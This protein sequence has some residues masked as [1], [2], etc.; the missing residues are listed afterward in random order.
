MPAAH[1]VHPEFGLLC[2][3]PRLRRKL[4]VALAGLV[5]AMLGL[6][7][8]WAAHRGESSAVT[9]LRLDASGSAGASTGAV[10]AGTP[11]STAAVATPAENGACGQT[12]GPISTPRVCWAS[13]AS[14]GRCGRPTIARGS[15]QV[16]SAAAPW[17][18][19]RSNPLPPP[20]AWP[21]APRATDRR[22]SRSRRWP[23]PLPRQ[24]RSR[25]RVRLP[26]PSSRNAARAARR[27]G[28]SPPEAM[29]VRGAR[30]APTIG[31]G[32]AITRAPD[33]RKAFSASS[34]DAAA[35]LLF[36]GA[37]RLPKLRLSMFAAVAIVPPA[38]QQGD[39]YA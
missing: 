29:R 24:C 13:C 9:A 6:V 2:P 27:A 10:A 15:R 1:N 34:G 28:A 5:C 31:P 25:A 19:A 32:P 20:R 4:R 11:R 17:P 33:S 16:R 26:P 8:I 12:S 35:A 3:T 37:A 18:P 30:S 36:C 7:A 21:M 39:R 38:A 22:P 14:R 23:M